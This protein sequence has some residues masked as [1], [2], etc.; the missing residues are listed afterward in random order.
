VARTAFYRLLVFALVSTLG[1]TLSHGTEPG[2]HKSL[3]HPRAELAIAAQT[4]V[5][6]GFHGELPPH[7][8]TLLGL[9]HEEKCEVMQGV[10]RSTD[11]IQG[12]DVLKKNHND[13]VLFTVDASTQDQVFY[14]TSPTG[15][16]RK[17]LSVKQG[18][19]NVVQPTVAD[20]EAFQK[21][22]KMWKDRLAPHQSAK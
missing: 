21:E 20:V 16:L 4:A 18:V 19:G 13:I 17:V 15:T 5:E 9:A 1:S 3:A 2:S 22:K 11:R 12:I 8:S 7:I 10:L 6:R 14:L